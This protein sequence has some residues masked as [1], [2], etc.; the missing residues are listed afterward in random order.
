PVLDLLDMPANPQL[1]NRSFGENPARVAELG[2]AMIDGY[3]RQGIAA[4]AKHFPGLGDCTI[5]SHHDLPVVDLSVARLE[6]RALVPFRAAVAAGVRLVMT[7]H[8]RYPRL[9]SRVPATHSLVIVRQLLKERLGFTGTVVTDAL[10][11]GAMRRLGLARAVLAA[12]T[13]GCDLALVCTPQRQCLEVMGEVAAG[14][15]AVPADRLDD[16]AGRLTALRDWIAD[17]SPP[18][19]PPPAATLVAE[20]ATRAVAVASDRMGVLPLPMSAPLRVLRVVPEML[21]PVAVSRLPAVTVLADVLRD[22]GYRVT[23]DEQAHPGGAPDPAEVSIL[24]VR[25]LFMDPTSART[26]HEI[27]KEGGRWVIVSLGAP[28]DFPDI[29][30]SAAW[31]QAADDGAAS[32]AAVGRVLTGG[33]RATGIP[34]N[35]KKEG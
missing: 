18:L 33:M 13:A 22:A 9:D 2:A 6:A 4:T 5:D 15:A 30:P 34:A 17:R 10:E 35:S 25:N 16:A 7:A 31:I 8:V 1:F 27:L 20:I 19:P 3:Q 21:S 29:P 14:M 32:L 26:W 28:A 23:V 11:M 12:I 24:L